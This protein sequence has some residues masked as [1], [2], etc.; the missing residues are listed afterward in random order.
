MP[1]YPTDAALEA[2]I[3]AHADE[4]TPRLAYADWL[5]EHGDPDRAAFIRV[6][7]RLADLSPNAPDWC[8]LTEQ[9]DELVAR[10]KSRFLTNLDDEPDRFYTGTDV[11]GRHEEPF[12]RGFPYFID[13][14]TDGEEWTPEETAA[15]S[16]TSPASCAPPRSAGST[17]TTSPPTR[18]PSYS[19]RR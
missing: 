3:V 17:R 9:Q 7:C 13:C 10:L 2:A 1:T 8:D 18:W 6:Q 11:I 16:P 5:D 19:P 15:W 14:Q 12:R 4:D